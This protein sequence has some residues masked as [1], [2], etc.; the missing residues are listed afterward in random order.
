[1]SWI[2]KRLTDKERIKR[3]KGSLRWL[4][5]M[6]AKDPRR[7]QEYREICLFSIWKHLGSP[8]EI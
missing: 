5:R 8:F 2:Q 4:G 7:K 3:I 1:M 6:E